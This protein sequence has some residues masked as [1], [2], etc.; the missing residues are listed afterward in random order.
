MDHGVD[1]FE[2]IR[3]TLAAGNEVTEHKFSF[4]RQRERMSLETL[5]AD[6]A[7]QRL[8]TGANGLYQMASDEAGSACDQN[9]YCAILRKTRS[10][11]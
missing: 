10:A 3:Q 8:A 11:K 9:L 5:A 7:A 4:D 6:Q 1:A 2:G